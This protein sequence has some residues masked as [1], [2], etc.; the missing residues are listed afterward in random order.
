[1]KHE[2]KKETKKPPRSTLNRTIESQRCQFYR[3]KAAEDF[4]RMAG[5]SFCDTGRLQLEKWDEPVDRA[6]APH[7]ARNHLPGGATTGQIPTEPTSLREPPLPL[8]IFFTLITLLR[9]TLSNSPRLADPRFTGPGG[10][11]SAGAVH[12]ARRTRSDTVGNLS[13]ASQSDQH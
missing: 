2:P 13:F 5:Y 7:A 11:G 9:E 4:W 12:G 6:E 3:L 8:E 1:M 10:R